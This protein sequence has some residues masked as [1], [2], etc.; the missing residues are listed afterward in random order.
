VLRAV[1]WPVG[2]ISGSTL[3]EFRQIPGVRVSKKALIA[4]P[5]LASRLQSRLG[6]GIGDLEASPAN[7]FSTGS[8]SR[9]GD[10]IA[11][12][13]TGLFPWQQETA[14]AL[15]RGEKRM[16]WH[17]CGLGK[18]LTSMAAAELAGAERVLVVTRSIGRDVYARD[19]VRLRK[20]RRIAILLGEGKLTS[21]SPVLRRAS[22]RLQDLRA[23]GADVVVAGSVADALAQDPWLLVVP[24]ETL[25]AHVEKLAEK[26]WTI[27]I[28]DEHHLGKGRSSKR[29]EAAFE[30]IKRSDFR[31]SATATPVRDRI[32]DLWSQLHAIAPE[33]W[34]AFWP[35]A[36]RYCQAHPNR[37]GGWDSHGISNLDE[38]RE[39][40]GY[41]ADVRTRA[42]IASMLPKKM[43]QV[44]RLDPD[45]VARA[46]A[47][48]FAESTNFDRRRGIESA[49]AYA[50]RAK[51][52]F[53]V[54]RAAEALAGREK[55]LLVGN[56]RAW[57]HEAVAALQT[58][59]A[60]FPRLRDRLWLRGTSGEA[61]I[62]ERQ[63]LAREFTEL[64]NTAILIAT[65][66]SIGES[67][68]I[69]GIDRGLVAA[70]PYTPGQVDQLE[71][72][73]GG[74]R[75]TRPV[76]WDYIVADGTI[77]EHIEE[78]LISKLQ[79][80]EDSGSSTSEDPCFESAASEEEVISRLNEKLREN[81]E[82]IEKKKRGV[83]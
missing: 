15:A 29:T 22:K 70:L 25:P 38:L 19:S 16:I 3:A 5:D 12:L 13:P 20:Q 76:S 60:K 53:V 32:R 64:E 4:S 61:S 50:A 81:W 47:L 55:V 34:G 67:I 6:K 2:S 36:K 24:W 44:I 8:G 49:I 72:R 73:S 7:R 18:S 57:V 43:R 14:L 51:L 31:W 46:H 52:G 59:V 54:E 62:D 80:V 69:G 30:L 77:D 79:A 66:D 83:A 40:L 9:V 1:R 28:F 27:V 37:W 82:R 63:A 11:K 39:R 42:E 17:G 35:W 75:Q 48:G 78:L 65:I 56:R 33:A 68:T 74:L 41:W 21:E 71:G 58:E 45:R 23:K 26:G 10:G